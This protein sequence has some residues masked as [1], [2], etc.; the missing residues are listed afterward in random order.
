M[1]TRA[2]QLPERP[3]GKR[4]LAA[5]SIAAPHTPGRER[6]SNLDL[7]RASAIVGVVC[8]HV[9]PIL[10]STNPLIRFFYRIGWEGV[11]LFFVLSGWLIGGLYW[12][13]RLKFG[14]VQI[15][16]FMLRRLIRTLPPYFVGL[17]L[18][19]LAVRVTDPGHRYFRWEYL[20]FLQ[21]YFWKLPFFTISWSLCVEEH[22]YLLMPTL[23]LLF[24]RPGRWTSIGFLLLGAAPMLIRIV[25]QNYYLT[26]VQT[27]Q[28]LQ[29]HLRMEGLVIGVYLSYVRW[30]RPALWVKLKRLARWLVLPALLAVSVNPY[31]PAVPRYLFGYTMIAGAFGV[32]I[33]AMADSPAVPLAR[34]RAVFYL[35]AWSYS[36]YLTHTLAMLSVKRF[37]LHLSMGHAGLIF[38]TLAAVLLAGAA[39]HYAFERPA[40]VIR[41]RVV[42]RRVA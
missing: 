33:A 1:K 31:L 34:Q 13:E 38:A 40:F 6:D 25:F 11:D 42:P 4:P 29:T 37:E 24:H 28:V 30:L 23:L 10:G 5:P 19:W 20:V 32:L 21:N 17:V 8:F 14:S 18:A 22:F 2:R 26:H 27:E 41:D 35:A 12:S 15:P 7:L 3:V 39:F 16:R 36:I 9:V